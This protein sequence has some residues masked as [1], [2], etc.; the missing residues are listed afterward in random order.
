MFKVEVTQN[1]KTAI[2]SFAT[3]K[4]ARE[5]AD[6]ICINAQARYIGK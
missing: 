3:A 6:R 4:I 2:Y 5:V 1:G